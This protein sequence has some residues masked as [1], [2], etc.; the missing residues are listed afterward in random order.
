[1][2]ADAGGELFVGSSGAP[3]G[4]SKLLA[5]GGIGNTGYGERWI[6]DGLK[7]LSVFAADVQRTDTPTVFDVAADVSALF[8]S[9][10]QIKQEKQCC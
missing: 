6:A 3:G 2:A 1:M 9:C 5:Q 4:G 8:S 7:E 10:C